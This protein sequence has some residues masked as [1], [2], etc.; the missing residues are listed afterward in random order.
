MKDESGY[1]NTTSNVLTQWG[2]RSSLD[3][4]FSN[5]SRYGAMIK[6][7]ISDLNKKDQDVCVGN[8]HQVKNRN[9]K[10]LFFCLSINQISAFVS[11]F[12]KI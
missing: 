8:L 9:T 6:T 5:L 11:N 3:T 4:F 10:I 7:A 2:E 1:A 12:S